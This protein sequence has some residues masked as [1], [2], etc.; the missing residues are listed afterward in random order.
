MT[1]GIDLPA[2]LTRIRAARELLAPHLRRTPTVF[3]YTF[4]ENAHAEVHLKLEN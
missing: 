1:H 4:S 3:S 2:A